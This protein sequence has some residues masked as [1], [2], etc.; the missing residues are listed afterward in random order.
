MRRVRGSQAAPRGLSR[1]AC[2][3]VR[4]LVNV[5]PGVEV[6]NLERPDNVA[7][8]LEVC[9]H[10][11]GG[12]V[13]CLKVAVVDLAEDLGAVAAECPLGSLQETSSLPSQS[14]LSTST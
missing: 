11:A 6:F 5:D 12:H 13:E 1:R 3:N 4:A 7:K 9:G 14:A 10:I 2:V 8:V